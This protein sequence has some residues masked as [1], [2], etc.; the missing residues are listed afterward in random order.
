MSN[1]LDI[2]KKEISNGGPIAVSR[3][4]E[5]ALAHPE[6]GYYMKQDPFGEGGDFI[7]APEISQMFGEL[8]GIWAAVVWQGMG[9]PAKINLVELGPGRGT[10][11]ADC[12]RAASALE[13]FDDAI[14]IHLVETSPALREIQKKTLLSPDM[15]MPAWRGSF[16]DVDDGPLI[17]IANEFFD[18]LP[19]DQYEKSDDGWHVRAIDWDDEL[20]ALKYALGNKL[21]DESS[22]PSDLRNAPPGAIFEHCA[23]AE[24][25]IRAISERIKKHGGAALIIDYGHIERGIGDTLQALKNHSYFD[26]LSSPGEADITAHVDFALLADVAE[27]L[28]VNVFGPVPQGAFLSRLG[29]GQ[30]ADRLMLGA[31]KEQIEEIEAAHAR[32]VEADQMGTLFKVMAISSTGLGIPPWT[33]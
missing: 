17:L 12:I 23:V 2:I 7:T 33:E 14:R 16:D 19:I 18:A 10:L 8:I 25:I 28:G 15:R 29:L 24:N 26:P 13:Q 21:E 3:Y 4:E 27:G 6:F 5:L 30:R 20:G 11:M 22:I 32:L 31:D 1:L 9:A